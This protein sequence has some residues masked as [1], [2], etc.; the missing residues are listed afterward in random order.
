MTTDDV[1]RLPILCR[2]LGHN[3]KVRPYWGGWSRIVCPRCENW[4]GTPPTAGAFAKGD[5]T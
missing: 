4:R 5:E 1:K 3:W 2:L